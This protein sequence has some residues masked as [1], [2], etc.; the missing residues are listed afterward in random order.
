MLLQLDIFFQFFG[1]KKLVKLDDLSI[2]YEEELAN[3]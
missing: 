3:E 2:F 1:M